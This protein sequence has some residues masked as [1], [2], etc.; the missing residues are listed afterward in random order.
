[1]A[2]NQQQA[3]AC[4]TL[5]SARRVQV[6]RDHAARV[7]GSSD[8]FGSA[9][10]YRGSDE[11]GDQYVWIGIDSGTKVVLS[12]YVGK[13]DAVSAYEFIGDLHNRIA[14]QHRCQLTTDGL[15][16]SYVPAIEEHFGA[17][18]DF[19]QLVKQCAKPRT[20][21]PDWFCPS[22]HVVTVIPT[23]LIGDPDFKRISTS[24]IERANL[25]VRM[26]LRRFAR[27][28]N[29]FSKKLENLKATVSVFMEWYNFCRVHQTLRVTPAMEAGLT[30]HIWSIRELLTADVSDRKAA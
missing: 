18:V 6:R 21:G 12:Y 14:E 27:L 25:T 1:M 10:C 3:E 30:D 19:A 22:S 26:H 4:C 2:C 29:G 20:D 11:F 17:E 13:R 16:G 9:Y 23:P 15:E 24:H 28:T 8:A 5:A 7:V